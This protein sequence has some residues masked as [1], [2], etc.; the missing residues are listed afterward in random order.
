MAL[1]EEYS[2]AKDVT[3]RR[4][5]LEALSDVFPKLGNKYIVDDKQKNLVPLLNMVQPTTGGEK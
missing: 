3:R 1:Y 2:K 5:Y 4:L